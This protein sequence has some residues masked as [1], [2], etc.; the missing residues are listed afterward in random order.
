ML[1]SSSLQF[2]SVSQSCP[3]LCNPM[4]CSMPRLP[5]HHQLP[6]PTQTQVYWVSH[7]IQPSHPLSFPSPPEL[8]FF[9]MF[10]IG[11]IFTPCTVYLQH[12]LHFFPTVPHVIPSPCSTDSA[13][14]IPFWTGFSLGLLRAQ[15][16]SLDSLPTGLMFL[17]PGSHVY[18][19]RGY[20]LPSSIIK[21][22]TYF[23]P[24][25]HLQVNF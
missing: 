22:V 25:S 3:T 13:L 11:F 24:A 5:V 23:F 7:A 19:S 4:N 16:G 21:Q 15:L 6:E 12:F 20:T 18:L 17:I 14:L 9:L 10:L 8:W 1:L 2:S